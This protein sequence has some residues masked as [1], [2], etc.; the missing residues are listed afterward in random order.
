[1]RKRAKKSVEKMIWRS[2]VSAGPNTKAVEMLKLWTIALSIEA[3]QSPMIFHVVSN[4]LPSMSLFLSVFTV[5][6]ASEQ[7]RRICC[8]L[9]PSYILICWKND[10]RKLQK[11]SIQ[12]LFHQQTCGLSLPWISSL[13]LSRHRNSIDQACII[14]KL[15]IC[16]VRYLAE[17]R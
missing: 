17:G 9:A 5:N 13:L 14:S 3:T 8:S 7:P 16:S 10:L 1:V 2:P 11:P 6:G 15:Q 4:S 12:M